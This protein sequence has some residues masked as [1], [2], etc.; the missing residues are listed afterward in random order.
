[1]TLLSSEWESYGRIEGAQSSYA[2]LPR[3]LLDYDELQQKNLSTRQVDRQAKQ[4]YVDTENVLQQVLGEFRSVVSDKFATEDQVAMATFEFEQK[5]HT[6]RLI[7]FPEDAMIKISR[8]ILDTTFDADSR[9]AQA[10]AMLASV[11][12]NTPT[13][14][15]SKE[16][17]LKNKLVKAVASKV[18]N[19]KVP[20]TMLQTMGI[21]VVEGSKDSLTDKVIK[22][23]EKHGRSVVATAGIMAVAGSVLFPNVAHASEPTP[24]V[25]PIAQT[26]NTT[27]PEIVSV[28]PS[29]SIL[30]TSPK[31][32][33]ITP[34]TG[35]PIPTT[36][37][38]VAVKAETK[39]NSSDKKKSSLIPSPS[40]A[41]GVLDSNKTLNSA[42]PKISI[43]PDNSADATNSPEVVSIAPSVD[44]SP[45]IPS[46][47][48]LGDSTTTP[49][50]PITPAPISL[51]PEQPATPSTP[52]QQLTANQI[53]LQSI[54]AE[55]DNNDIDLAT[56]KIIMA[57]HVDPVP[58]DS[59][60][61]NKDNT[62]TVPNTA[63]K[64]NIDSLRIAYAALLA[65]GGHSDI[66][67]ENTTI[68]AITILNAASND[69]SILQSK[70]LMSLVDNAKTP[71][72]AYQARVF[73]TFSDAATKTFTDNPDLMKSLT[74]IDATRLQEIYAYILMNETSDADLANAAQV[75]RDE[76]AKAAAEKLA[77]DKAAADKAAAEKAAADAAGKAAQEQAGAS[78]QTPEVEAIQSMIDGSSAIQQRKYQAIQFYM[79]KGLT[80]M[81]AAAIVGNLTGE[82]GLDPAKKQYGGGIGRDLA[83]WSIG[84]HRYNGLIAYALS[85]G[86]PETDF[87]VQLEYIWIELNG[88]YKGALHSL[89][90]AQ[91]MTD[92]VY[93]IQGKYEITYAYLHRDS[94]PD[95]FIAERDTRVGL[96]QAE[97]DAFVNKV[98]AINAAR[99]AVAKAKADAA[100]AAAALAASQDNL[101]KLIDT[102]IDSITDPVTHLY[103]GPNYVTHY[104]AR[105][106]T[107]GVYLAQRALGNAAF[108]N[109]LADGKDFV[110]NL[111][112]DGYAQDPTPHV[113]D[114]FSTTTWTSKKNKYGHTG[115]VD[116]VYPDM[117]IRIQEMNHEYTG[118]YDTR[119]VPLDVVENQMTFAK[120]TK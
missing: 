120:P 82:S 73:K 57:F 87:G 31:T 41:Q 33:S 54:T 38:V 102:T 18:L 13:L 3:I 89:Q 1:M 37:E 25:T 26:V 107:L 34:D 98:T 59:A 8:S 105:Q 29:N 119:E 45:T 100:A 11:F 23:A 44:T 99:A 12:G 51:T 39:T 43:G 111:V 104:G 63:L 109:N 79:N 6:A 32:I 9:V 88:D 93:A 92:A 36:P 78:T 53:A 15:S 108:P 118:G 58:S 97:Y 27:G 106:C 113:G 52:D 61:A 4:I 47:E 21:G 77:A 50:A 115:I 76:D 91:N 24:Q 81:Q 117:H 75:L 22:S 67:A 48:Q 28:S 35:A 20:K 69:L 74:S 112:K 71:T 66:N 90:A 56:A 14:N 65:A 114:I 17:Y 10:A 110:A 96:I 95:R 70:D 55:I 19:S 5:V 103:K 101:T 116:F 49:N 30:D 60:S 64:A 40:S 42:P 16:Q 83:Q 84:G 94:N 86:K 68:A 46:P 80:G 7:D 2:T 85:V 72:D 62:A